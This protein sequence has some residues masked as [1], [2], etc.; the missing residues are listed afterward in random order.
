[1]TLHSSLPIYKVSYDLLQLVADVTQHFPRNFRQSL[2]GK[3]RD[4]CVELL[5][6]IYRANSATDKVPHL[7]DLLER[8]QVAELLLRLSKDMRFL[9]L[10]KY[11]RA[12][13][14][15]D[16]IGKQANGWKKKSRPSPAA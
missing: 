8:L 9:S 11:A 16:S 3:L 12:I 1:M 5:V 13:Q 15:T 7:I 10:D 6:L 2:G 14:F 4:E